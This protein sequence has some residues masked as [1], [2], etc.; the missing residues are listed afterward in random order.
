VLSGIW[1]KAILLLFRRF[2]HLTAFICPNRVGSADCRGTAWSV[3]RGCSSLCRR[4]VQQ[5][6][7]GNR[8]GHDVNIADGQWCVTARANR[9]AGNVPSNQR[10][11]IQSM[12]SIPP[13]DQSLSSCSPVRGGSKSPSTRVRHCSSIQF[14]FSNALSLQPSGQ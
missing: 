7:P 13:R 3:R 4:G 5:P 14:L 11:N 12:S 1:N 2:S 9:L 10:R 8:T 6:N